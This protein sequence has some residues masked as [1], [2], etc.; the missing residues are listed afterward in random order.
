[1]LRVAVVSLA[2]ADVKKESSAYDLPIAVGV[3]AATGQVVADLEG[4]VFLG[5]LSLDGTLRHTAGILPMA[6]LAKDLGLRRVYVPEVD[7][8]EAALVAGIAVY[9][10]RTLAQLI[11]H[12][13]QPESDAAIAPVPYR[14][15]IFSAN[16]HGE[17]LADL[18]EVR[19]QEH[20]KR[21][22]EVAAA[23]GHTCSCRARP[24]PARPCWR[25]ACPR[26]CRR[27]ASTRRWR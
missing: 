1:M 22:V 13:N 26:S 8:N 16:G 20:V 9:P 2:P 17:G 14:E 5:E 27:W 11:A 12:L 7:A 3:L 10:V 25:A 4:T 24:A 21:A 6:S 19:G 15:Q 18:R 23:V